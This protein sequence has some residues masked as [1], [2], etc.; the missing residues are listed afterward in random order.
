M[1][2]LTD[3]ECAKQVHEMIKNEAQVANNPYFNML[4][5]KV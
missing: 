5:E 4:I 3:V 2:S 1:N